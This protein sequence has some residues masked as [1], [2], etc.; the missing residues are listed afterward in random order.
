MK[1][2]KA[3]DEHETES[4]TD[5]T[6]VLRNKPECSYNNKANGVSSSNSISKINPFSSVNNMNCC[7]YEK[8]E[9]NNSCHPIE[10]YMTDCN[11]IL[12]P[13]DD[14]SLGNTGLYSWNKVFN[15]SSDYLHPQCDDIPVCD[16]YK[17]L[18]G[19]NY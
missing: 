3:G 4:K 9:L 10:L 13:N 11:Q 1:Y 5:L 15:I 19:L 12:F 2:F 8:D 17:M 16:Y 7:K 6:E 18:E 14:C